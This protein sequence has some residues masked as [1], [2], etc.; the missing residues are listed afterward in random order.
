M[1][2]KKKKDFPKTYISLADKKVCV[3][4]LVEA[5]NRYDKEYG[6]RLK[7]PD[8]W[9]DPNSYR[10]I[11]EAKTDMNFAAMICA[12][13]GVS[14]KDYFETDTE[15]GYG[16]ICKPVGTEH[17][18]FTY[19]SILNW[20][21]YKEKYNT[22]SLIFRCRYLTLVISQLMGQIDK[23]T[24]LEVNN[25][26]RHNHSKDERRIILTKD[27]LNDTLKFI[28]IMINIDSKYQNIILK[29]HEHVSYTK[30]SVKHR[31]LR[32]LLNGHV[33]NVRKGM[34]ESIFEERFM[35][36]DLAIYNTLKIAYMLAT[37]KTNIDV[38]PNFK[39]I[40]GATVKHDLIKLIE[41]LGS[42]IIKNTKDK[43]YSPMFLAFIDARPSIW[44]EFYNESKDNYA[45]QIGLLALGYTRFVYDDEDLEKFV[46]KMLKKG[47]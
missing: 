4:D 28:L 35:S 13:N 43:K 45:I 24:Y 39:Y 2:K 37:N 38:L 14:V 27:I 25:K 11:I 12:L 23:V 47:I 18:L 1:G 41:E 30:K 3:E 7:H 32:N 16:T 29:M 34:K 6:I 17:P 21:N 46:T 36:D 19:S 26:Y 22:D 10:Q 8:I 15:S 31:E 9:A 42:E 33:L 5:V 40:E 20:D 44:S